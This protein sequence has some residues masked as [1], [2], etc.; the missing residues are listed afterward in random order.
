M[1]PT[2]VPVRSSIF[3]KLRLRGIPTSNIRIL[4]LNCFHYEHTTF[5]D[6][7]CSQISNLNIADYS[8]KSSNIRLIRIF[9]SYFMSKLHVTSSRFC[10]YLLNIYITLLPHFYMHIQWHTHTSTHVQSAHNRTGFVTSKNSLVFSVWELFAQILL[11][12]RTR[13][14]NYICRHWLSRNS[15]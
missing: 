8:T 1:D 15:H 7:V 9:I 3:G 2:I 6:A 13:C 4:S 11:D 12:L 10:L 5:F 14:C